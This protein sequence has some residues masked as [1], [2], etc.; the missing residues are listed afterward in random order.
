MLKK[1][2]SKILSTAIIFAVLIGI[3]IIIS[4]AAKV[5][6]QM[7]SAGMQKLLPDV[8]FGSKGEN[9]LPDNIETEGE[10]E[11]NP[12]EESQIQQ[13]PESIPETPKE[14]P[15]ENQTPNIDN[16]TEES[17]GDSAGSGEGNVS[18]EGEPGEVTVVTDLENKIVTS[19]ELSGD[20]FGFFAYIENGTEKHSLEINFKN[21]ETSFSGEKLKTADDYYEAKLALGANYFTIFLLEDGKTVSSVQYII[22]YQAAKADASNPDVGEGVSIVTNL[23]GYDGVMTNRYF[24]FTVTARSSGKVIYSDHIEVTLDGTVVDMP[25]GSS[26]FE[27]VLNFG[28]EET[29]LVT[30]LAWDD[31]GNSAYREYEVKFKSSENGDAIGFA[32]V[33][34]DATPAGLGIIGEYEVEILQGDTA[35]KTLVTAADYMGLTIHYDG[36]TETGFYARGVSG[37]AGTPEVPAELWECILRDGLSITAPPSG[38]LFAGD[39]TAHSGWMYSI[40][41]TLFPGKG[42]SAYNLSDGDTLY[43]RFTVAEGKDI[44]GSGGG[45]GNLA[46]YCGIWSDGGYYELDHEYAEI[47]RGEDY[48]EYECQICKKHYTEEIEQEEHIHEY[49]EA[50]RVEPTET[51]DG[52]VIYECECGDY[53]EEVLPAT[54]TG[55]E[56][57]DEDEEVGEDDE[58]NP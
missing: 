14:E 20:M 29:H 5:V 34:I 2:S 55:K 42:L 19:P 13:I 35:A 7:E 45:N 33:V 23:D 52:Y 48:I 53:Y 54:G 9:V 10:N 24:T 25:T 37:F 21:S 15:S 39:F 32:T 30:V 31:E 27:Y 16:I 17:G 40:N 50:E 38:G 3:V 51:E 12:P 22:T 18:G 8:I 11:E 46:G 49:H 44:G 56:D 28:P 58:E 41:G 1:N 6:P 4:G 57:E 47:D 26:T 36:S 43:L